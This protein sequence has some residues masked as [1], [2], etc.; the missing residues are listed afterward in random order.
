MGG[1][2]VYSPI[3]LQHIVNFLPLVISLVSLVAQNTWD[4]M[5]VAKKAV[6]V[7]HLKDVE[8]RKGHCQWHNNVQ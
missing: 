3:S 5:E 4:A 6:K 8:A 7:V 1:G 2:A